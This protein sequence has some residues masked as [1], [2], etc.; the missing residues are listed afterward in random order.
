MFGKNGFRLLASIVLLALVVILAAGSVDTMAWFTDSATVD[1]NVFIAGT[2]DLNVGGASTVPINV[3][4]LAPGDT[5][6]GC[7]VLRNDGSLDLIFRMYLYDIWENEAGFKQ[8]FEITDVT[9][10][11]PDCPAVFNSGPTNQTV[12]GPGG[13]HVNGSLALTDFNSP[14]E[15]LSSEAAAFGG[16]PFEPGEIEVYGVSIK[17]LETTPNQYQAAKL[18]I[19]LMIQATQFDYQT[20][21]SVVW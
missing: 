8:Y 5:A 10:N 3:S 21:G 13:T 14:A 2:V 1:N 11:P 20:S 18:N 19:D 9:I 12:V 17:L 7:L 4:N 15:A 6:R 16:Y